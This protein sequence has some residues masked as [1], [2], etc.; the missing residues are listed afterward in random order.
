MM[1]VVAAAS[2]SLSSCFAV[3]LGCCARPIIVARDCTC[4]RILSLIR[5]VQNWVGAVAFANP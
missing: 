3:Y 1:V 2:S 5:V 4:R